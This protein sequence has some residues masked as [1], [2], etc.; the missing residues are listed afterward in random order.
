MSK[1]KIDNNTRIT[2]DLKKQQ[3]GGESFV[4]GDDRNGVFVE[5][6]SEAVDIINLCDG[7][8]TIEEIQNIIETKYGEIYNILEFILDLYDLKLVYMINGEIVE[9]RNEIKHWKITKCIAHIFFNNKAHIVYTIIIVLNICM[10]LLIQ[11]NIPYYGNAK[12]INNHSGLSLLCFSFIGIIITI[13]HEL[14]HYLSAVELQMPSKVKLNLRLFYLVVETDI[15]SIWAVN[16][17]K[18]YMCYL[19]G[20]YVENI[21]LLITLFIKGFYCVGNLGNRICNAIIL[22]IFLNFVWQLMIFLRTDFYYIILNYLNVSTLHFSAMQLLK[23]IRNINKRKIEKR[24][25]AYLIV[26]ILGVI[27]S[28][29]YLVNEIFIYANLFI[30]S[31]YK[32]KFDFDTVCFWGVMVLNFVM[33]WKGAYNKYIEYKMWVD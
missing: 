32:T 24:I 11:D 17:N 22:T 6:P 18:R 19:A 1:I 7:N 29:V 2:L 15:N 23:N 26:Y 12:I 5:L 10:I 27:A 8:H 14:G 21:I 13:L 16:R 3:L 9:D 28:V 33:W 25:I 30:A 31:M 4:V 20:F